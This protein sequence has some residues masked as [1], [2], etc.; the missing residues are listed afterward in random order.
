[1]EV[2]KCAAN[3]AFYVL[4]WVFAVWILDRYIAVC[5]AEFERKQRE[6]QRD[7]ITAA[8]AR[9]YAETRAQL[10]REQLFREYVRD[11]ER[12]GL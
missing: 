11:G 12:T 2:I 7:E 3:C 1:M 4:L 5:R 6:M 9:W 8:N 10:D